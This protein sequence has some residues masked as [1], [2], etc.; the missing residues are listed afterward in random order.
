MSCRLTCCRR[1]LS[2]QFSAAFRVCLPLVSGVPRVL[3][4]T[5]GGWGQR[6]GSGSCPESFRWS[7][8]L[9]AFLSARGINHHFC[10]GTERCTAS[11]PINIPALP[12]SAAFTNNVTLLSHK[13]RQ[14]HHYGMDSRRHRD[15]HKC[16]GHG[17]ISPAS[18]ST[19]VISDQPRQACPPRRPSH[20]LS[21]RA[22]QRSQAPRCS[23]PTPW[24]AVPSCTPH[25]VPVADR[26]SVPDHACRSQGWSTAPARLLGA[27]MATRPR[28]HV[29]LDPGAVPSSIM[30]MVDGFLSAIT[31]TVVNSP[32]TLCLAMTNTATAFF[33]IRIGHCLPGPPYCCS[34]GALSPGQAPAAMVAIA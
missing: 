9:R 29:P 6:S 31:G 28:I 34:P 8:H 23:C 18:M 17:F 1:T 4:L 25:Q 20:D 32:S 19:S 21:V 27:D 15:L 13:D 26:V 3:S 22:G 5:V 2:S 7:I 12:L 11:Y 14:A 33:S 16:V 30:H 10:S 24:K